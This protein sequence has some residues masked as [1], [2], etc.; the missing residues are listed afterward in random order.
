M[1]KRAGQKSDAG[2]KCADYAVLADSVGDSA[3]DVYAP[4][5][6]ELGGD[7][8]THTKGLGQV[9]YLER[10]LAKVSLRSTPAVQDRFRVSFEALPADVCG[11]WNF[12]R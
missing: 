9:L 8:R 4:S 11:N 6:D 10:Y 3:E 2:R 5:L 7:W 12:D 1:G